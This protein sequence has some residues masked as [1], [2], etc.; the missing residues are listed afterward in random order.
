MV[1]PTEE[2][3]TPEGVEES[4]ERIP[5]PQDAGEEQIAVAYA[6][7][8]VVGAKEHFT[9]IVEE[10]HTPEEEEDILGENH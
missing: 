1:M 9:G 10:R 8:A 4:A 7:P 3:L 6:Q 5:T 2:R